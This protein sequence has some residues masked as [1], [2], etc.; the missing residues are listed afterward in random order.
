MIINTTIYSIFKEITFLRYN[1]C[2][3]QCKHFQ[4][5]YNLVSF[6]KCKHLCNMDTIKK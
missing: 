6:D 1:V 5:M 3:I 2:K 4:C